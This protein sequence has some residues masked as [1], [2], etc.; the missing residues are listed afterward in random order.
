MA[1]SLDIA[2]KAVGAA[3]AVSGVGVHLTNANSSTPT[4]DPANAFTRNFSDFNT[5]L[6]IFRASLVNNLPA[7]IAQD[8]Q[9][10]PFD[11]GTSIQLVVDTV[12]TLLDAI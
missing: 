5:S 9:G 10:L 3:L 4:I 7:T 8:I 1:T 2:A 6:D 11:G 12:A